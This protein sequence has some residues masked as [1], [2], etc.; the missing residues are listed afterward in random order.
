MSRMFDL[1]LVGFVKVWQVAVQRFNLESQ[2][3]CYCHMH[4]AFQKHDMKSKREMW[5]INP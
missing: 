5:N 4:D 1:Y 3:K 2:Y